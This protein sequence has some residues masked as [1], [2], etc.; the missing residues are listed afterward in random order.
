MNKK[1]SI[2]ILPVMAA[3][4]ILAS[5]A[6]GGDPFYDAPSIKASAAYVTP[7]VTRDA[8]GT[9][10]VV[11][12]Q[13]Y[14]VA[15][16]TFAGQVQFT[17]WVGASTASPVNAYTLTAAP[18]AVTGTLLEVATLTNRVTVLT[19]AAGVASVKLIATAGTTNAIW[20]ATGGSPAVKTEMIWAA[21]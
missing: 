19:T 21:P 1:S 13:A 7:T 17:A 14:D 5:F 9:T 11:S 3:F 10:N 4:A 20:T 2:F 18:T 15:G 6:F 8:S 16:K 12:F